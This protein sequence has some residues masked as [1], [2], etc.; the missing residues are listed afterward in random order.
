MPMQAALLACAGAPAKGLFG[1]F[2]E[3]NKHADQEVSHE[4]D[5]NVRRR[6]FAEMKKR[7]QRVVAA[8]RQAVF[9]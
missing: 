6:W 8:D 4:P 1:T 5:V 2:R 3:V 7:L 9:G